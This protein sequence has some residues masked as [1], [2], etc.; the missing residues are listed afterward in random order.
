M[1]ID[2][3]SAAIGTPGFYIAQKDTNTFNFT[4]VLPLVPHVVP[5][6]PSPTY[7]GSVALH[8]SDQDATAVVVE[9]PVS[10]AVTSVQTADLVD[11]TVY[12]VSWQAQ[13][14]VA[15]LQSSASFT[16]VYFNR[17]GTYVG[18][19]HSNIAFG[20]ASADNLNGGKG[21]DFIQA[22]AGADVLNGGAG[23]DWLAGGLGRDK[24]TGGAGNDVFV[25]DASPTKSNDVITDFVTG[26][27]T[28]RLDHSIFAA[29]EAGNVSEDQ[30]VKNFSGKAVSESNHLIYEKDTGK[31]YYDSDGLGGASGVVIAQLQDHQKIGS[32]DFLIV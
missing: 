2:L 23:S 14:N 6:S 17:A 22:A 11:G 30:F 18:D 3:S 4:L 12:D 10:V 28:I 25:F 21:A 19:S 31:I 5:P 16:F 27:D 20:S 24:L 26:H 32:E 7:N 13:D 9:Q 15:H 8:V 1:N 29:F